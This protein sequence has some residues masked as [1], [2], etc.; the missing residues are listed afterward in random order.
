ML[1]NTESKMLTQKVCLR[2]KSVYFVIVLL[3]KAQVK[4]NCQLIIKV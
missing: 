4:V 3:N 1:E 2:C